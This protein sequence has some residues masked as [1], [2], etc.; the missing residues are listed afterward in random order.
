MKRIAVTAVLTCASAVFA[1]QTLYLA[2]YK[3]N[4]PMLTTMSPDGGGTMEVGG[5]FPT[6]DWL[7]V[8][9]FVDSDAGK[10]YW[11]HGGFEDGRIS[12]AN[13]D[14][15]GRE[16]LLS[17]LTNPRGLAVDTAAG[18]MFWSD[19][20]DE[21]IYRA[22]TEGDNLTAIVDSGSQYGRPTLDTGAQRVYYGNFTSGA[23]RVCD[24]DGNSDSRVVSG[25]DD[26]IGIALD[27]A[28][29]K[30]YWTDA[31]TFTN[32]VARADLDGTDVEI[33]VDF[34]L[35]SSGLEDIRIDPDAGEI[36]WIDEI[37]DSERGVWKAAL[38]GSGAQRIYESPAGW[39]AGALWLAAG[40][41]AV[42]LNGDGAVNTQDVIL[43]LN[44]W[45]AGDSRAD[46]NGDGVI[47]TRDFIAF[48]N[49][50]VAAC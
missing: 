12:R 2:E 37:T 1:Q 4:D 6:Q 9:L 33:L 24:Y 14:G 44:L 19:T 28:G 30:I 27:L 43:F 7:V 39:N 16:V 36:Y 13:L 49:A 35:A 11:T 21:V 42:D 41:C 46:W 45:T 32:Y 20:Q 10:I 47:D 22:T 18:L 3:F 23:I 34:P 48:L 17:G 40:L 31:Q 8:G 15:S 25:G 5:V 26:P 29:G 50:W 38:D